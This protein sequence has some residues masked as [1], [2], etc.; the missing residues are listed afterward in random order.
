MGTIKKASHIFTGLSE[1]ASKN[2]AMMLGPVRSILE[3]PEPVRHELDQQGADSVVTFDFGGYELEVVVGESGD[4]RAM[5]YDGAQGSYEL[6]G[7]EQVR[8]ALESENLFDRF[9]YKIREILDG[10]G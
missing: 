8:A 1:G 4:A 9:M 6:V 7:A 5:Y 10:R 2:A 3:N